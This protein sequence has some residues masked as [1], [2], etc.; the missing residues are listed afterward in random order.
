MMERIKLRPNLPALLSFMAGYVDTA[1]FLALH[2]LFAAHVTG[3][4][5]TF[6]AAIVLGTSGIAAKLLAL[7]VFCVVVILSRLLGTA[8]QRR[9]M[10][11]LRFVLAGETILLALGAALAARLGPFPAEDTWGGVVTGM[12]LVSAMAI[13]NAAHRLYLPAAPPTTLMTGNTTQLM[14]DLADVMRGASPEQQIVIRTR[15]ARMAASVVAF[16]FGCAGGAVLFAFTAKWCFA[17]P[18][19]LGL[20]TLLPMPETTVRQA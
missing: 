14:I 10:T 5:V 7:P 18:P 13:Q 11:V 2:G 3:N 17:A 1:G 15:I 19:L 20:L 8:L 12:V 6:G 16:A 4:F 9:G